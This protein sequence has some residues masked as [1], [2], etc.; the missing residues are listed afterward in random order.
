MK[1]II[2]IIIVLLNVQY[3]SAQ[4]FSS[5]GGA[6]GSALGVTDCYPYLSP[7]SDEYDAEILLLINTDS[8]GEETSWKIEDI[9]DGTVVASG[10]N[11]VSDSCYQQL[12]CA[13]TD[14]CYQL[15]VNDSGNN[16]IA[17][18]DKSG[19][20]VYWNGI[21]KNQGGS[22]GESDTSS[23]GAC[24]NDFSVELIGGI[25]CTDYAYA[26]VMVETSGGTPPF[27]YLWSN[28]ATS[29]AKQN[30]SFD[31]DQI[32]VQVTDAS[33]CT[34]SAT[35]L[36]SALKSLEIAIVSKSGSYCTPNTGEASI[37]ITC[38]IP[39]FKY[40]WSNGG[41]SKIEQNL[42]PGTYQATVTDAGNCT[43][44][45]SVTISSTDPIVISTD[46]NEGGDIEISVSGG[47]PPYSFEWYNTDDLNTVLSTSEDLSGLSEGTYEVV[48]TDANGCSESSSI[49][50]TTI[51]EK[52]IGE[53]LITLIPNP[54]KGQ[55]RI[56]MSFTQ[57]KNVQIS[58]IDILGKTLIER[59]PIVITNNSVE[60]DLS[61]Y[62]NGVY[63]FRLNVDGQYTTKPFVIRK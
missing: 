17:A 30:V 39:P 46:K 36:T 54:T 32:S 14:H 28:G 5:S 53:D 45:K 4:N 29:T 60:F 9:S 11:L 47:V 34:A 51:E 6:Q 27:E 25:P 63:Y 18:A 50:K 26:Q 1:T 7:C 42:T 49:V 23:L 58:L 55:V 3:L 12:V 33:N 16:G 22:F 15:I 57:A 31:D 40:T 44:V 20:E 41:D 8:D 56:K 43:A 62:S 35:Y 2:F 24:C 52:N 59:N 48:V 19:Y 10:D 61:N 13:K 21:L 37:E 38:G